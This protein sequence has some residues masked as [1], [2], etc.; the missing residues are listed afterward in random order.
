MAIF[1]P[2]TSTLVT[3]SFEERLTGIVEFDDAL[4]DQA[5]W[6]NSRYAGSRLVAKEINKFSPSSSAAG[7]PGDE[8]YQNLPVI[9]KLSTA[10]YI[11]NTVVGGEESDLFVTLK[12][13]SYVSIS[14]ILLINLVDNTVQ[15]LDKQTEPYEQFHRFI[16]DDFPTGNS[17]VAKV[18]ENQNESIPNNLNT[19]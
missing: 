1:Y 4:L 2:G 19:E 6:K 3:H 15:I 12:G 17:A 14:Q 9:N 8:S 5:T 11:S 13:H 10:L 7:W 18:I 16:V